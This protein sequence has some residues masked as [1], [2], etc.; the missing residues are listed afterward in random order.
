MEMGVLLSRG[1]F[2]LCTT[3]YSTLEMKEHCPP[4]IRTPS[5]PAL[6]GWSLDVRGSL[7][8]LLVVLVVREQDWWTDIPGVLL[9]IEPVAL[10]V[11]GKCHR[12]SLHPQPQHL[13]LSTKAVVTASLARSQGWDDT[14]G[15]WSVAARGLWTYP[16]ARQGEFCLLTSCSLS[17]GSW[18]PVRNHEGS[19]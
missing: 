5:A 19:F 12:A 17:G 8:T 11:P 9:R 10:H 13:T 6:A 15:F 4:S 3:V 16:W 7:V 1:S 18:G 14:S 2:T